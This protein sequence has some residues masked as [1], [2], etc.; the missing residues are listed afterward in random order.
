[1]NADDIK[2]ISVIGA[3][4]MGAGIA[5]V[6]ATAGYQVQLRDIDQEILQQARTRIASSLK[7]AHGDDR[8]DEEPERVLNRIEGTTEFT[9]VTDVRFAIEAVAEQEELKKDVF[10]ELDEHL[11]DEAIMVSNTSSISLT[12]LA[13]VVDHPDQVA[14]MH[15]F[16][17]VPAMKLVEVVNAVQSSDQTIE[18]VVHMAENLGKTPVCVK[19]FPGFVA[20]R[21]LCPMINEAIYARMEGVAGKEEIDEI[22]ELGMG[23]PMGPL[24]LAD[25]VGLDVLLDVLEVLHEDLGEDKYRPCPLL[26]KK[27][28]AGHLGRKSGRGFYTY[29]D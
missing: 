3:G 2:R 11:P 20:N 27:V 23:H 1:M 22:M 13:S 25:M 10:R 12:D 18:T 24:E 5:Q 7:R 14:G 6:F 28:E 8:I 15:F 17:P 4:T 21:I 26:R 9:D 29:D 19:D 16:N